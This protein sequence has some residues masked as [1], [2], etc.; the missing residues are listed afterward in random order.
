[1]KKI[2]VATLAGGCFWCTE[3]LFKRLRG[4]ESVL[5]GYSGGC[6]VP[7]IG[8]P[9]SENDAAKTAGETLNAVCLRS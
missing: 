5:P 2:E 8:R 9:L 3:A 7:Q 4:V 6:Q 1:M